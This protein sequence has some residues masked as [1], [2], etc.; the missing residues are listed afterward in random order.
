MTEAKGLAGGLAGWLGRA[1][2]QMA[3]ELKANRRLVA[4]DLLAAVLAAVLAGLLAYGLAPPA[5]RGPGPGPLLASLA[6]LSGLAA[7]A[8]FPLAGFY[9]RHTKSTSL[10]DIATVLKGALLAVAGTAALAALLPAAAAIPLLLHLIQFLLLVPA[11]C[12]LR[13]AARRREFIRRRQRLQAREEERIPIL[14]AGTGTSCD[15][16][17]RSLRHTGSR[18]HPVGIIDDARNTEGLYF[19]DVQITGSLRD[20][21]GVIAWLEGLNLLPQRLL[22]TEPVTHFDSEGIARLVKWC[23]A[24]GIAVSRLAGLDEIESGTGGRR[25][26]LKDVAPEDILD[27]PQTAVERSRLRQLLAGR[28]VL[29]TGA[30]GSIGSELCRQI[31]SF[32]P[33]ELVMF[34]HCELNAYTIGMDLDQ[35]FPEVPRRIYVGSIRDAARVEAV[36][37]RHRPELVF[38]AAALKHV[39]LVEQNPCEGVLTNVIGTRNVADAARSCGAIAMVQIST[40]KAV[41]T[42]N[43]M[44]A[45]KR[46]AEFYVQA[47]DR[48]TNE[49][50]ED[51][52]FFSV[53]FGNVLGSSGSLIPLFQ[54]QISAG[55]PLTVTDPRME[56]YFMTIREAVQLTLV[57]AAS[58]LALEMSH[59]EIFVLDMGRPV[60][61][62][63][64]AERMIRLAGRTPHEDIKIKFIGPRPGEKLFEEL[65]DASEERRDP[66]IPGISAARPDGVPISR[67]R[68][69]ILKLE[70]AARAGRSSAVRALL[71][72]LVPGYSNPPPLPPKSGPRRRTGTLPSVPA[73]P[74]AGRRRREARQ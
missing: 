30:G 49:T 63:D 6:A 20:P 5:V 8:V 54:R 17:L 41:N 33:A 58:G 10:R 38:N 66:G 40:D 43:V 34:D 48:V 39:P 1:R 11:L 29:V 12:T 56:R 47:Q 74:G 13:V 19:H 67:L 60:K 27:R 61:I 68:A 51:T 22:L 7:A 4:G 53:R 31:A 15:L 62:T 36:F 25:A 21:A 73:A 35:N 59:G 3:A 72:D 45:T 65:F 64:L 52:R 28:R 26:R 24:H 2:K 55:G 71:Q 18:Y 37:A 44:G 46:V 57:A 42:T 70:Q 16:F 14:L 50:G 32:K 23:E 69:M 9:R